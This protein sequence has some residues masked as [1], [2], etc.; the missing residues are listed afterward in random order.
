MQNNVPKSYAKCQRQVYY[1]TKSY[2]QRQREVYY[3]TESSA[4]RQTVDTLRNEHSKPA[5]KTENGGQK[6]SGGKNCQKTWDY[7][8]NNATTH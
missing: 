6:E 8:F 1:V 2:A 4:L 7:I 5:G 3:V